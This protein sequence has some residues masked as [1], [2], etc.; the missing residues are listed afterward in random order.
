VAGV[1]ALVAAVLFGLSTALQQRGTLQSSE[2]SANVRFSLQIVRRPA[3]LLGIAVMVVGGLLQI[4][5]QTLGD[6]VVIQPILAS[7]LVFA[8]PS[9]RPWVVPTV[10]VVVLVGVSPSDLGTGRR[11]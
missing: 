7:S 11:R 8:L 1:I 3:W 2:R 4:A 10:V 9:A 6:L 5:A